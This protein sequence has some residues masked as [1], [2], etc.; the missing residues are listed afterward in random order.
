MAELFAY[1]EKVE[2]IVD[3]IGDRENDITKSIAWAFVKCPNLM[4]KVIEHLLLVSV[5]ADNAVIRYQEYEKGGGITDL[6]ITDNQKF[7]IIIEAKRGVD[8][9]GRVTVKTV[10]EKGGVRQ[11][12]C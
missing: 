9:S 10:F 7:Y 2:T 5:D 1:N 6:E 11:K 4:E 12:S 3:L 8:S